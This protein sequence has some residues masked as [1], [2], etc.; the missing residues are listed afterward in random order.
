MFTHQLCLPLP[1]F[2]LTAGWW[3]TDHL[4]SRTPSHSC[5]PSVLDLLTADD[6]N[7]VSWPAESNSSDWMMAACV[8]CCVSSGGRVL[9]MWSSSILLWP[10]AVLELLFFY[11]LAGVTSEI[12]TTSL[13]S[14]F[15]MWRRL[16]SVPEPSREPSTEGTVSETSVDSGLS[17]PTG[18][19]PALVPIT[20][21]LQLAVLLSGCFSWLLAQRHNNQNVDTLTC[22]G[23]V[24]PLPS[25]LPSKKCGSE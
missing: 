6:G 14:H 21:V 7:A 20:S 1:S 8:F 18:G 17:L 23:Q 3:I 19:R 16:G 2:L 15:E 9:A 11:L 4:R 13:C 10:Q 5:R 22:L 24:D 25:P 12:C